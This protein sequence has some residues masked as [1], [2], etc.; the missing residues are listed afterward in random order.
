MFKPSLCRHSRRSLMALD[1]PLRK[2][3]TGE[4]SISFLGQKILS[5][6]GPSIKNVRTLSSFM[7]AIKKNILFHLVITI[8]L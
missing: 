5:K 2:E 7:R 1:M 4:K 8:F 6:I 3:N